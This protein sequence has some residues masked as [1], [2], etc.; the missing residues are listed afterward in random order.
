M[1]L[2]IF[3]EK[4]RIINTE[5]QISVTSETPEDTPAALISQLC[6]P[7][8]PG[9]AVTHYNVL[10]KASS[11][12][13]EHLCNNFPV[14]ITP[15]LNKPCIRASVTTIPPTIRAQIFQRLINQ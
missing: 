13:I 12:F 5:F 9:L 3:S 6:P 10:S 8:I 14:M 4:F 15:T 11:N 7:I 1:F 2:Q